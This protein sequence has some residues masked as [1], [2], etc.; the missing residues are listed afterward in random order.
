MMEPYPTASFI[1]APCCPSVDSDLNLNRVIST[2]ILFCLLSA[3]RQER[4][5]YS[6]S[7]PVSDCSEAGGASEGFPGP[8]TGAADRA[9]EPP[10]ITLR[11]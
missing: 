9:A 1:P 10:Q 2:E 4:P 7:Q 8:S 3:A 11:L 5:P 6:E